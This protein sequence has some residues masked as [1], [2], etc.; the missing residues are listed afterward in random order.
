M[1]CN[2]SHSELYLNVYIYY[3]KIIYIKLNKYFKI[4]Y[5]YYSNLL[6]I[7]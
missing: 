4:C 1:I 6:F 3:F 5:S 2:M 7:S